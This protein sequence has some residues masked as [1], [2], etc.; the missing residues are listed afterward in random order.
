MK[1][2][3][4]CQ[5]KTFRPT[6]GD[7]KGARSTDLVGAHFRQIDAEDNPNIFNVTSQRHRLLDPSDA[8]LKLGH[9]H[10]Q[11]LRAHIADKYRGRVRVLNVK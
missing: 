4:G 11:G 1:N 6:S 7:P 8:V 2:E 3:G 9:G 10:V 5:S